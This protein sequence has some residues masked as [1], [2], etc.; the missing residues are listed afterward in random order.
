MII[1][2]TGF[3][4]VGGFCDRLWQVSLCAA[5]AHLREDTTLFFREVPARGCPSTIADLLEIQGFEIKPWHES[6][7]DAE[8][9][10]NSFNSKPCLEHA[11]QY[12]PQQWILAIFL[13]P[14][15]C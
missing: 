10:L 4:D 7:G 8:Y 15:C 9:R 14:G 2:L 6:L 1:D 12:K 13:K 11:K 3:D 5:L